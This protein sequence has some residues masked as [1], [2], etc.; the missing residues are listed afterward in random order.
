MPIHLPSWLPISTT[1]GT[2]SSPCLKLESG[3]GS[4]STRVFSQITKER[5]LVK[6]PATAA[7]GNCTCSCLACRVMGSSDVDDKNQT[8]YAKLGVLNNAWSSYPSPRI[9]T[10]PSTACSAAQKAAAG[11]DLSKVSI[12]L[13]AF[14]CLLGLKRG[15]LMVSGT[16]TLLRRLL[17][18]PLR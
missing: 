8:A 17:L 15:A 13:S 16:L 7:D 2:P 4:S 1:P 14:C 10:L 9:P 18:L 5:V 3:L 6:Q 11:L 12:A